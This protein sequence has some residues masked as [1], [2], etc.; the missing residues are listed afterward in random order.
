MLNAGCPKAEKEGENSSFGYWVDR[1][2]CSLKWSPR[3]KLFKIWCFAA[4]LKNEKIKRDG[5]SSPVRIDKQA[6]ALSTVMRLVVEEMQQ[7]ISACPMSLWRPYMF[8]A[9]ALLPQG[10]LRVFQRKGQSA[11]ESRRQPRPQASIS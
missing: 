9:V 3:S 10:N 1:L 7:D 5:G 4:P 8:Y 6:C 11:P 2:S